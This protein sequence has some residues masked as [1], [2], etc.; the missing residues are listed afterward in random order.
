MPSTPLSIRSVFKRAWNLYTSHV[1]LFF[2]MLLILV[3]AWLLLEAVVIY[4]QR[5][6]FAL[7]LIAHL[8]FLTFF[9]GYVAGFSRICLAIVDGVPVTISDLFTDL[10]TSLA[11]LA[12]I[13]IYLLLLLLGGL[14]FIM[15]GVLLGG[16]FNF[17]PFFLQRREIGLIE[18]FKL[19]KSLSKNIGAHQARF[20]LFRLTL[21]ILGASLFG[22]GL[23]ITIPLS[24][25][26]QA[27]MFRHL[28][29]VAVAK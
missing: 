26:M 29:D 15:P 13:V 7:W 22:L 23:F 17:Y 11:M 18:S 28:R 10:R 6:G 3:G 9:A 27:A 8:A 5:F 1:L 14:L 12:A 4:G 21:N 16:R 24:G 25:L 19:S 20:F 2:I